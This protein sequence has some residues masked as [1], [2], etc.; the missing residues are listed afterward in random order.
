MSFRAAGEALFDRV[1][2]A[3]AWIACG[4]LLFQ[5]GSVSVDVLLRYFFSISVGWITALNEWS[6]VFVTFLGAA[7]LEREGGHTRDDSIL[8]TLG[9]WAIKSSEW[10][11]WA[12]GVIVCLILVSYG[13][14]VTWNNYVTGVYDFFKLRE[15]PIFWIYFIIPLGSLLWLLQLLRRILRGGSAGA[16]STTI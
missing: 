16:G 5:V 15:V 2:D 10:I 12:L 1:L 4:L 9:P 13:A 7:W 14:R 8:G 3:C 11:S 6:L